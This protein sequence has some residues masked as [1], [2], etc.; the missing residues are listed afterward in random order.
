MD[1]DNSLTILGLLRHG[2]LFLSVIFTAVETSFSFAFNTHS[3]SWQ[4]WADI[5]ISVIFTIDFVYD[6]KKKRFPSF[7]ERPWKF[8][9]YMIIN[10]MTCIPF[11][12]ATYFFSITREVGVIKMIPLIRLIRIGKIFFLIEEF[13]HVSQFIKIQIYI[14][15]K[16]FIY[17]MIFTVII[18]WLAC[19]WGMIY[20]PKTAQNLTEYYIRCVY[21]AVSTITTGGYG[22]I[23][24]TNSIGRLFTMMV[25]FV[26]V[27]L[28]GLVIGRFSQM[29]AQN[30][31]R[32]KEIKE[33]F[34]E[35]QLFMMDYAIPQKLQETILNYYRRI[36]AKRPTDNDQKIISDLPSSLQKELKNYVNIKLLSALSIFKDCSFSCIKDV[37]LA[38]SHEYYSPREFVVRK[39]EI[40]EDMYIIGHGV[41]EVLSEKGETIAVLHE[42]GFFGERSLLEKTVRNATVRTQ[43]YCDLYKLNK[44]DF[45]YIIEKHP[46]LLS[47]IR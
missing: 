1:R 32:R 36:V 30:A 44:K 42:G 25:M 3:Q 22:D 11:G 18:H 28:Y 23:A 27:G 33:K 14:L 12:A 43:T 13:S 2:I 45:L 29:F 34:H 21:W 40:G 4:F 17:A 15:I 46:E 37:A 41:L 19:I 5:L 7:K 38:L 39:N 8:S 24:P 10:I 31:K 9:F 47:N 6:V 20:P 16:T 26:G 35:L